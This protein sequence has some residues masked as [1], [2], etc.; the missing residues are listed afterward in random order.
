MKGKRKKR[1][2]CRMGG[3]ERAG[4][5]ENQDSFGALETRRE[6]CRRMVR[7]TREWQNQRREHAACTRR[8]RTWKRGDKAE[9]SNHQLRS[10]PKTHRHRSNPPRR[11]TPH[12]NTTETQK[13]SN[14]V[15]H[16][17]DILIYP[18][19]PPQPL[20]RP[21]LRQRTAPHADGGPL[22]RAQQLGALPLAEARR[23]EPRVQQVCEEGFG[24]AGGAG[25][26]VLGVLQV[27][28]QGGEEVVRCAEEPVAV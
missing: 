2:G 14:T 3:S 18:P 19:P 9:P 26:G 22:A 27:P 4:T 17:N 12:R 21:P 7:T 13:S 16:L 25:V 5:D 1:T 15:T 11:K 8:G 10:R 23:V 24:E 28:H 6:K 20:K